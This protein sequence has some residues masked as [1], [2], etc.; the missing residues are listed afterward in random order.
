MNLHR[1]RVRALCELQFLGQEKRCKALFPPIFV[2]GSGCPKH[3]AMC[4]CYS[5]ARLRGL[6][7]VSGVVSRRG[8][9]CKH[10]GCGTWQVLDPSI[11][12]TVTAP[13]LPVQGW[14]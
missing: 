1:R 3:F 12:A 14:L 5:D 9:S 11:G 8:R 10:R 2:V 4:G 7:L 6:L 13:L